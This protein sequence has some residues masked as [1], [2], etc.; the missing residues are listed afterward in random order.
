MASAASTSAPFSSG[1]SA[2]PSNAPAGVAAVWRHLGGVLRA[3]SIPLLASTAQPAHAMPRLAGGGGGPGAGGGGGDDGGRGGLAS[4]PQPL[5]TL[6]AAEKEPVVLTLASFAVTK[7]AYMRLTKKFREQYLAAKGIDVRFRLTFAGSG[8]QA[9][10]VIDGLPADILALALPLDIDR[11]A[12]EGLIVRHWPTLYPNHSVVCETTVAL[13]VRKDNPKAI[14]S[15][16]DLTKPGVQIVVANPKTAGVARWIFLALWG[17]HARRGEA[18]AEAFV[19]AVFDNVVV[20]PRDARE[21]SDVFYKQRIG[22]VL[23]TYENEVIL[24]NEIYGAKALPYVVPRD[25][26]RIACPIAMVERVISQRPPIVRTAADDFIRFL[27]TPPGQAEFARL[28]FRVNPSLAK[29]VAAAQAG[30]MPPTK[31][32]NVDKV[33]GSWDKAQAKFFDAGQVLDRIQ[34]AIGRRRVEQRT[35]AKRQ[36]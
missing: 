20:Q 22:D 17:S 30:T 25:N 26:I 31:L 35:V 8:V 6:A 14:L 27:F 3:S 28:G 5:A 11:V 16:E 33:F 32:W 13:V 34:E 4:G 36:T 19:R 9:R 2:P 12:D 1:R 10:A 21:A 18:A 23:L 15:W 24:T 29:A 7:L